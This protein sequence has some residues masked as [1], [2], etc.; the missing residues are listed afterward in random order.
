M[1]FCSSLKISRLNV[2]FFANYERVLLAYFRFTPDELGHIGFVLIPKE[3]L[4]LGLWCGKWFY[5]DS[6]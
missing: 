6:N 5:T 2:E 3:I 1:S 4:R